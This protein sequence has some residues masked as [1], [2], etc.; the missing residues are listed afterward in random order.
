VTSTGADNT[1]SD[2]CIFSPINKKAG[3][4]CRISIHLSLPGFFYFF[5]R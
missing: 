4:A 3:N 2:I 5:Y 1:P